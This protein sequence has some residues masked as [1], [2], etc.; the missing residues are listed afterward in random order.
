[1]KQQR[2]EK[3]YY[4]SKILLNLNIYQTKQE[5]ADNLK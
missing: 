1:M 4:F 5:I 2:G 3:T